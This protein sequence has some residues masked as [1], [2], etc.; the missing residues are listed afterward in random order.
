MKSRIKILT[1]NKVNLEELLR[2]LDVE[3][4]PGHT[5]VEVDVDADTS[6]GRQA[7]ERLIQGGYAAFVVRE[8][9]PSEVIKNYDPKTHEN[10]VMV[11]PLAG[12]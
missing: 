2:G 5:T 12:G 6:V 4:K 8:G 9:E 1:G 11:A 3:V 7:F 10:V